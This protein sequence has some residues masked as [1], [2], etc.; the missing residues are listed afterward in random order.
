MCYSN[1]FISKLYTVHSCFGNVCLINYNFM[2]NERFIE[3]LYLVDTV[4]RMSITGVRNIDI[5]DA[6]T[7]V[8][9]SRTRSFTASNSASVS[10]LELLL[11]TLFIV[12]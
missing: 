8:L 5:C 4:V 12:F 11:L 10:I 9:S 2:K 7:D 3:N 6:S 1:N